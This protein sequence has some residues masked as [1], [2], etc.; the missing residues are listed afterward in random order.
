MAGGDD[1]ELLFTARADEAPG[2]LV[3]LCADHG[4]MLSRVGE[5]VGRR[6][7][8]PAVS[9]PAGNDLSERGYSHFR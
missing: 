2:E 8:A 3:A 1:Y 5:I 9:D 6:R 7:G 4:C